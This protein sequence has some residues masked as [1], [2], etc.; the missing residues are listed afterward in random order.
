MFRVHV[1]SNL[2]LFCWSTFSFFLTQ[3]IEASVKE[4]RFVHI[5]VVHYEDGSDEKLYV[6]YKE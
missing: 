1:S 3:Y 2:L 6:S 4:H 5:E